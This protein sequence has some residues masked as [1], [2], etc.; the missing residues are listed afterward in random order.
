MAGGAAAAAG[1]GAS[2]GLVAGLNGGNGSAI[3]GA[4]GSAGT[5]AFKSLGDGLSGDINKAGIK[6]G[7]D[8]IGGVIGN[9]MS[10]CIS[11]GKNLQT[12]IAQKNAQINEMIALGTE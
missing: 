3:G 11:Y 7:V 1:I 4:I 6:A 9:N 2:G 12:E 5:E 8:S 10:D